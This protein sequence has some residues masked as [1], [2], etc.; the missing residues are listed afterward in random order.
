MWQITEEDVGHRHPCF[1]S[2][3]TDF[4]NI[5]VMW[6]IDI[7]YKLDRYVFVHEVPKVYSFYI[8]RLIR[9]LWTVTEFDDIFQDYRE[10]WLLAVN[11]NS[12]VENNFCI[13]HV[14]LIN[15][16]VWM[17]IWLLVKIN[18]VC[19][20]WKLESDIKDNTDVE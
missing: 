8:F 3:N 2:D 4:N 1:L 13:C 11:S 12:T 16:L 7:V 10:M 5:E 20:L 14:A 17:L 18:L 9:K 6:R 19:H 15:K